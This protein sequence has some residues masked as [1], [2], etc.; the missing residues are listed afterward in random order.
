MFVRFNALHSNDV[1]SDSQRLKKTRARQKRV[2]DSFI[3][4]PLCNSFPNGFVKAMI[5]RLVVETCGSSK[6][7]KAFE[8]L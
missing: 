2:S 3:N 7:N 4:P 8:D 6:I 5:K 1:V